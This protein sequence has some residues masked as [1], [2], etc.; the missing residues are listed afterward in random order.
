MQAIPVETELKPCVW[1]PTIA[2]SIAARAALEDLAVLVDEEVVADVV[3]AVVV[4]VVARDAEHDRRRVGGCVAVRRR[5]VVDER[6][7]HLA[8]VRRVARRHRGGAPRLA[9]DDRGRADLAG[10]GAA[11][12]RAPG[13][14]RRPLPGPSGRSARAARAGGR[15]GA[16][17]RGRRCPS[18]PARCRRARRPPS[19]P[20]SP[21]ACSGT[22][23]VQPPPRRR[24]R[25]CAS[26]VAAARP[27][28]PDQVE[29]ARRGVDARRAPARGGRAG[30]AGRR[31]ASS[32]GRRRAARERRGGAQRRRPRRRRRPA[33]ASGGG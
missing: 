22:H 20:W 23:G 30:R 13:G 7:L 6:D 21:A 10:G 32:N 25:T 11:G 1:A 8:V 15:G 17:G 9:G 3:P 24:A 2:W 29:P 18:T 12:P 16:A 27:A 31:A 28:Q 19:G 4:A 5:R 14:A 33:R 26:R